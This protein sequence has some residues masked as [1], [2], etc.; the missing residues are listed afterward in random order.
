[1]ERKFAIVTDSACDMPEEYYASHDVECVRLGFLMDSVLYGGEDGESIDTHVF[2][3]RMRNDKAMPTTHQVNV[4]CAKNHIEKFLSAGRDVL[5]VAF[6]SG[7]SGTANSFFVAA[8]ELSEKYPERKVLVSDSLCASMGE[9]LYLDYAVRKADTGASLQETY[10]YLESIKPNICHFFTVDNLF[11]LKRGGR[12]SAAVAVVGTLLS[13]KPVMHVD[14]EGH[15]IPIG[16]AMG[17][18]KS[19]KALFDKMRETQDMQAG[20]PVFISHG[21]CI[22]DA[23]DLA[24]MIRGE[25]PGHEISINFIGPVIGAHSGPGTLALFFKGKHR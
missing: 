15:L 14:D 8:K 9:G 16:K 12:V 4:E 11:H 21:D 19:I 17:R 18:K 25:F 2:Y 1:M 10:D 20:D 5:V 13:I 6:S 24:A 7:L 23:N 3:E 22:D